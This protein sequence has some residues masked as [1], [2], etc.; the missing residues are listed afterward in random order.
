VTGPTRLLPAA[1]LMLIAMQAVAEP[2]GPD[3]FATAFDKPARTKSVDIGPA[4][5]TPPS[6]KQV[7]CTYFP[8][9]MVKEIDEQEVGDAQI[10][11]LPAAAPC[12]RT[13]LPDERVIDDAAWHG[14]F[15]GAHGDFLFLTAEDGTEGGMGFAV[16]RPPDTKVLYT[17][18]AKTRLRF[19]PGAPGQ[20]VARFEALHAG[21]CSVVTKGTACAEAI[22]K[23][24]GVAPP[25]LAMCRRSYDAARKQAKSADPAWNDDPSVISF[26]VVL[27]LDAQTVAAR[28]DGPP[29]ACWMA[30]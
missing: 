1:F 6:R 21:D 18:V 12:Q 10:S 8:A 15:A 22:G 23:S 13:N 25:D 30:E 24:V 16:M 2:S 7:R 26:R 17:A 9:F 19:G 29:T 20:I 5:T 27:T 28:V 14:Y 11:L 3:F 4:E